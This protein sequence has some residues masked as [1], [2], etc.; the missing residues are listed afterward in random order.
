MAEEEGVTVK[1]S[2]NFS[3]WYNQVVL[4]AKLADY[5]PV[6]GCMVIRPY[7]YAIWEK[8][9]GFLDKRIKETGHQNA[10]FP[11]FIPEKFF[12]KEAE[13]VEGFSP[14][15]A[16]VTHGGDRE[17]NEKLAIRPTSETIINY[18]YSQWIRSYRDLP[19]LINQWANI[20]RWETKMTKLFMRTREFLWQEGHTCHASKKEAD[21]EVRKTLDLYREVYEDLLAIPVI[22]GYKTEMEKF[23][24]AL[25]TTTVE[26]LMPDGRAI[27]GGTSHNLGQNFAKPFDITYTDENEQEKYVW[28]TSWGLTTRTIAAL[29]MI[30]SDD[31][32][33]VLPPK[34]APIEAVIVPIVFEEEKESVLEEARKIRQMITEKYSVEM[35]D[36]EGYTAGYKFN[37]WELKGVPVRIEVGPR[38]IK[39]GQVVLV[40]R[41]TGEKKAV[42]VEELMKKIERLFS[43]IQDNLYKKAKK[44]L[45]ENTVKVK[46]YEEF[47]KAVKDRKMVKAPFCGSVECEERI[48]DETGATSA[49]IPFKSKDKG[50]CILCGKDAKGVVYFAKHY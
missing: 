19:L 30:H 27:Q 25:Y 37:D 8:I 9:K 48:K 38:D 39:K 24:G 44:N 22:Q 28:Q 16:W 23:A 6:K 12:K 36:R 50:K 1:K 45:E 33:L 20:I 15:V 40:R 46:L 14:E 35:D 21:E 17:L 11:L 47:K 13:H 31:K 5:S 43:A 3:E 34:V 32:G 10:Y 4:K 42:K 41:D 49:C 29:V 2:E 26:A 7:G 18:M